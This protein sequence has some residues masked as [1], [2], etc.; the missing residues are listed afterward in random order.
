MDDIKVKLI[1]FLIIICESSCFSDVTS[2]YNIEVGPFII[3]DINNG[4]CRKHDRIYTYYYNDDNNVG[5]STFYFRDM[6][7]SSIPK[8]GDTIIE[9][10]T[11]YEYKN[12]WKNQISNGFY[13][14]H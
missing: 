7:V 3:N 8:I 2:S 4:C 9:S 5:Y 11:V 6:I 14:K 12:G 13:I 10:R 1:Y